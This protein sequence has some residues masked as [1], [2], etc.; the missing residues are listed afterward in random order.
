MLRLTETLGKINIA[1]TLRTGEPMSRHTTFEVGGPAELY[2]RPRTVSDVQTIIR[3]AC[4]SGEPVFILGG[5]SNVLVSDRGIRGIVLDMRDFAGKRR[6]GETFTF[7]AGL[8][9]SDAAERAAGEGFGGLHFL[10]GM[11]GSVG[12][13]IWMN[14]RC[15]GSS[16]IDILETVHL[17]NESGEF[18]VYTPKS[19]DFGYKRSP[20]QGR[21]AVIL[22]A[23]FGLT[24]AD[25][26]ELRS[27]MDGY[28]AD[29]EA[30]GHFAA[31]SAGSVFKNNRAFGSPTGALVD[32]LGL[33]GTQIG[34]AR[35]SDRH[36]N[37][38]VNT[39]DATA[40]D[41]LRLIEFIERRVRETL[42]LELEREVL[43]V[44]DWEAEH[45]VT[46]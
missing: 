28:Y 20:F 33:R 18:E 45:A 41:I 23:S 6:A 8:A 24:P 31:P 7:G 12:G 19:E 13:A 44:G 3:A 1:G 32:S 11:P 39:G 21:N 5:G 29:R 34:G 46:G 15:Y 9:V 14:A 42:G 35:L 16:V 38:I 22:E 40:A 25:P 43:L 10:Y 37:I 17:V 26:A 36:A 2:V 4:D 27:E 30:K